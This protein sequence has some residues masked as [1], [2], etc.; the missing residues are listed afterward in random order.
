M[1]LS[2]EAKCSRKVKAIQLKRRVIKNT[3]N[4]EDN[5][6]EIRYKANVTQT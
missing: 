4:L 2:K 6:E 1:N 3:S 5:E